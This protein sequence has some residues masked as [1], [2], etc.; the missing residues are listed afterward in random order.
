MTV[1][2]ASAIWPGE[3]TSLMAESRLEQASDLGIPRLGG[4]LRES[5]SMGI[6][7]PSEGWQASEK[8]AHPLN[9]ILA[10]GEQEISISMLIDQ[11]VQPLR[12]SAWTR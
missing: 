3:S 2:R 10:N 1:P 8:P 5:L 11:R 7:G 12:Y 4:M 6:L 9:V